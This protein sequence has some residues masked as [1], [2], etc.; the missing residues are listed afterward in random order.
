MWEIIPGNIFPGSRPG[1][2]CATT[3]EVMPFSYP[4]SRAF[5][6]F[7]CCRQTCGH[8]CR[9]VRNIGTA[10]PIMATSAMTFGLKS[11]AHCSREIS[12]NARQ[13]KSCSCSDTDLAMC[14]F[15]PTIGTRRSHSTFT[16][17]VWWPVSVATSMPSSTKMSNY[18]IR[19]GSVITTVTACHWFISH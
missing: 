8:I 9:G 16:V 7:R 17:T 11:F 14:K 1:I 4:N 19:R 2:G 18:R 12:T 6:W 5:Q 10:R 15:F 3:F 13:Y